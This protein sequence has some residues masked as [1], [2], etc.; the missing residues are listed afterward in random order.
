MRTLRTIC[1]LRRKVN[2]PNC[3]TQNLLESE[4]LPQVRNLLEISFTIASFGTGE[5]G[6]TVEVN[7]GGA[8]SSGE[9]D[10]GAISAWTEEG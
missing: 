5:G 4:S 7:D 3:L 10:G 6:E 8:E 1:L 2:S 9:G